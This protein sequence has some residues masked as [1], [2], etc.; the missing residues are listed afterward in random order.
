MIEIRVADDGDGVPAD[1]RDRLFDRYVT[2]ARI[3]TGLAVHR[4]RAGAGSRRGRLLR[5]RTIPAFVVSL[6]VHAN[7]VS[8]SDHA[9]PVG[10]RLVIMEVVTCRSR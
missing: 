4:W 3:G 1:L 2:A 10:C 7:D 6:P 9:P 8:Q 5:G